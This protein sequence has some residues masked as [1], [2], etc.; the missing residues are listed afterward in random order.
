MIDVGYAD[1]TKY[2][3]ELQWVPQVQQRWYNMPL[4][5]VR[6]GSTPL[7]VPTYAF[8]YDNDQIGTFIDR[9]MHHTYCSFH[10]SHSDI[11]CVLWGRDFLCSG[12]SIILLAPLAFSSLTTIFQTQYASLPG[13]SGNSNIFNGLCVTDAQ[14]GNSLA[15]FPVPLFFFLFHHC[16]VLTC[17][18]SSIAWAG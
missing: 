9:S 17:S 11:L 1:S 8:S 6:V 13:V 4:R 2:S 3:G 16:F 7:A 12:T 5:T 15:S 14:M 18:A 10:C